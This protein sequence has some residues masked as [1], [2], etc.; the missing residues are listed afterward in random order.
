MYVCSCVFNS[1][2]RCDVL[3]VTVIQQVVYVDML[4]SARVMKTQTTN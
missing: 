2:G 1:L 3:F 4:A